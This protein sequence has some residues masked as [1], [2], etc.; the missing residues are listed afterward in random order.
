MKNKQTMKTNSLLILLAIASL[1][2]QL[3]A[4]P[5]AAAAFQKFGPLNVRDFG[6]KGDGETDDTDAIQR[7][8]L[9]AASP[10]YPKLFYWLYAATPEVYFPKGTYLVS[11]TLLVPQ[12]EGVK[13]QRGIGLI[14]LRG[15]NATIK[16]VNSAED[17]LYF[18]MAY[19]NLIEGLTFDGGRR[20]IKLWS[21]NMDQGHI[22]I[23]D[24]VF[25]NSSGY[26]IDDQ[27]RSDMTKKN[28]WCSNIVEP[29]A[30]RTDAQGLPRLTAL[31]ETQWPMCL[32][33]STC[34][35]ISRCSF[36]RCM[37]A[38]SAWADFVLMDD[39]V[40]ETHPDMAGPAIL[41]GTALMIEN[42]TGLAHVRPDQ[43]AWW[44]TMSPEKQP[45]GFVG[46]V[47]R[48]VKLRTDARQGFC[49]IRN[50]AKFTGGNHTY[51][52]A[53]GGEFKSAG[54]PEN[55][56]I[57]LVE[58]P[59]VIN[60]RNCRETSGRSVNILG[61]EKPFEEDYLHAHSP[62]V[63]AFVIDENNR[64]LTA[65]LPETM[66]P[67]AEQPLPKEIARRF[68]WAPTPVT[69]PGMRKKLAGS[70]NLADFGTSGDGRADDSEAFRKAF[71]AVRNEKSMVELIVPNGFYR[72]DEPVE[73]PPRVV[74]RASGR[75]FFAA[76]S[77]RKG[78]LFTV[79]QAEQVVF[80]NLGFFNCEQAI[81]LTT[82]ADRKSRILIDNCWF[83]ETR[84]YAVSCLSGT[85]AVAE[86]NQTAL[87][88]SDCTFGRPY[89][90]LIHNAGDA[91]VDNPW[92]S[93][94]ALMTGAGAIANKGTLHLQSLCGV[95]MLAQGQKTDGAWVYNHHQVFL[96]HCRGGGE[97][98][99][100]PA[101]VNF[102]AKG[103]V[104][105]E[106]SWTTIYPADT[107][108][109]LTV[110]DCEEIPERIALRGNVAWPAPQMMVTVRRGAHGALKGRWFESG[111]TTPPWVKDERVAGK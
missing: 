100:L 27:L 50:E 51:I 79:P 102:T 110:V 76:P 58:P 49:A 17:I 62:E 2:A 97:S 66:Q 92:I 81:T 22:V 42:L 78:A 82:E 53:D 24:C 71:A 105:L 38:L 28:D 52:S 83:N 75:A 74:V 21:R 84:D 4:E 15:E 101:V 41:S 11:R 98:G 5:P 99:G 60:I 35:R 103:S 59:N 107:P 34:M 67:F 39:C 14:N 47:L 16:Q 37:H 77:G 106:N 86:P 25:R 88:I 90:A 13:N 63:F 64:N 8:L 85:G 1:G 31:D 61:Y 93:T 91:L 69:L 70:L 87:R 19:R 43:K 46:L 95:P 111:N 96:D 18:Q 33:V 48:R 32:F 30:I 89:G 29:Y 26:A 104:L 45:S 36:Q 6:A 9:Q 57:H 10:D 54:S 108:K 12:S 80:Q 56:L 109:R 72:L 20:Q 3:R 40:I 73:V 7:C 68:E 44:I 65:N 94:S 23:R 55:C